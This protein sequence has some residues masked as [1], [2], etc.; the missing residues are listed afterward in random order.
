MGKALRA[1]LLFFFGS[2]TPASPRFNDELASQVRRGFPLLAPLFGALCGGACGVVGVFA[3]RLGLTSPVSAVLTLLAYCLLREIRL[4]DGFCDLAE[5]LSYSL[6][7]NS[8]RERVWAVIR[9]PQNG[10][11]AMLWI[12]IALLSQ[13]AVLDG[14]LR[15]GGWYAAAVL[16]FCGMLSEASAVFCHTKS[17]QY[18]PES[19]FVPFGALRNRNAQLTCLGMCC[20]LDVLFWWILRS[21]IP[22]LLPVLLLP[23]TVALSRLFGALLLKRL[24][25]F[26]GDVFGFVPLANVTLLLL[27]ACLLQALLP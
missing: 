22:A 24:G 3:V 18:R 25:A 21:E 26:N 8:D 11:F 19:A 6:L 9:S 10:A 20:A 1:N 27:F 13:F 23:L 2:V 4:A 7:R 17:A 16:A 14:F 5:G 15:T 12:G